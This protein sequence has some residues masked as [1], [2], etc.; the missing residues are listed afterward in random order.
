MEEWH[1][2][3]E[4]VAQAT[5]TRTAVARAYTAVVVAARVTVLRKLPLRAVL[6]DLGS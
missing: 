1:A 5:L 4:V 6:A 3:A 2:E